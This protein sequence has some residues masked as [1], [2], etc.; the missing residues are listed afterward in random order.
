[1]G[2]WSPLSSAGSRFGPGI[3]NTEIQQNLR[4]GPAHEIKLTEESV[5]GIDPGQG[6]DQGGGR[7]A[8]SRECTDFLSRRKGN[9]V[10][11]PTIRVLWRA[12]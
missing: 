11:A 4:T 6:H 1:M 12:K 9:A 8:E 10:S 2:L 3:T 7:S 5:A